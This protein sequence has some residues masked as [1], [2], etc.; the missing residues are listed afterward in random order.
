MDSLIRQIIEHLELTFLGWE[1]SI[2]EETTLN[3]GVTF[4]L[5]NNIGIGKQVNV[6]H[7]HFLKIFEKSP[8]SVW[9]KGKGTLCDDWVMTFKTRKRK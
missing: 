7:L 9:L 4:E 6:S 8:I 5:V 1:S 3:L 2:K